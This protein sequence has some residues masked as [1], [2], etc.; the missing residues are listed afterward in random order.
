MKKR[1]ERVVRVL[2]AGFGA[3]AVAATLV[4][5]RDAFALRRTSAIDDGADPIIAMPIGSLRPVID[6]EPDPEPPVPPQKMPD[7]RV[8]AFE[9]TQIGADSWRLTATVRNGSSPASSQVAAYPGGGIIVL[10]RSTGGTTVVEPPHPQYPAIPDPSVT[11]RQVPI[12]ALASGQS[13]VAE[14]VTQGRAVFTARALSVGAESNFA[15]NSKTV[16]KLFPK[17]F[18]IDNLLLKIFLN[19]IVEQFQVHLHKT[20][21]FVRMPGVFEKYF[22]IPQAKKGLPWPL[23]DAYWYVNDINLTNT[24]VALADKSLAVSFNFE[25]SGTEIIGYVEDGPDWLAPNINGSPLKVNIKLPLVFNAA[26]QCFAYGTPQV[27][28]D[29]HWNLNNLPDFLLPDINSKIEGGIRSAL[30]NITIKQRLEFE[31][32]KQ[33]HAQLKNARIGGVVINPDNVQVTVEAAS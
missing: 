23:G 8:E 17:T 22:N 9:V 31:L 32:N 12:P 18:T 1:L 26:A 7:L 20:D 29:A 27:K 10:S 25:T 33:V 15:N 5:P 6:P 28:M 2:T 14:V 19:P 16:S 24:T 4:A 3:A 21:S 13:I 30:S 11:L